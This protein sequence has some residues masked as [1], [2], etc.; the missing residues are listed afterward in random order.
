MAIYCNHIQSDTSAPISPS[1]AYAQNLSRTMALT[2]TKEAYEA[3]LKRVKALEE[4]NKRLRN[5]RTTSEVKLQPKRRDR[6]ATRSSLS[7]M[8]NEA[9][10]LRKHKMLLGQEVKADD[11]LVWRVK[12]G[13]RGAGVSALLAVIFY[14][15][16]QYLVTVVFSTLT[17]MFLGTIYYKNHSFVITKRLLREMNVEI[18]VFLSL[19]NLVI[20][21]AQPTH[22]LSLVN[23]LIYMLLVFAFAFMDAIKVKSRMFVIAVGILFVFAEHQ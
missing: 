18:M 17:I 14:F 7:G 22:S 21:I 5:V 1:R 8:Y 13:Q 3:L 15:A 4:E 19:C 9:T 11:V 2:H 20:D 16:L 10:A 23:G 12:W 6:K